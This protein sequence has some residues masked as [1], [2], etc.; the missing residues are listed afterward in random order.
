[1]NTRD[2]FL[3]NVRLA[4]G[5]D[6][7]ALPGAPALETAL[8]LDARSVEERVATI[9]KQAAANADELLSQLERSATQAGWTVARV[10]SAQDAA[11]HTVALAREME[12]RS[13]L[14]STH[15]AMSQLD[16]EGQLSGTGIE[17]RA[18]AIDAESQ[19][20]EPDELRRALRQRAADADI[21]ITGVDYAV[22]ETGTAVLIA[23]KGVSRLVS[24]L[25]PVHIAVVQSGQVL[26]S[27]DELFTLRRGDFLSG[28]AAGYMNLISGPSRSGDIEN[29]LVTGYTA[30]A[31]STW[32]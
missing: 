31:R 28:E 14:R 30:Q 5:R 13:I 2:Q 3:E 20:G 12:A 16:L 11:H 15:R 18:M 4:L 17:I 21:G 25:P 9:E 19:E 7:D 32:C 10:A 1:M 23:R 6:R 29:T 24:L 26:P 27:L 22:A 8:S